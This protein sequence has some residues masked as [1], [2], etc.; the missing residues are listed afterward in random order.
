ML[1]E[2]EE[3]VQISS[4]ISYTGGA[5]ADNFEKFRKWIKPKKKFK[6]AF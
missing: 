5:R 1:V 3:G 2:E 6:N 4:I